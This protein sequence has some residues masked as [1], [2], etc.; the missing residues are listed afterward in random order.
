MQ[1]YLYVI[2]RK[3]E[4]KGWKTLQNSK[5]CKFSYYNIYQFGQWMM[6]CFCAY[7]WMGFRLFWISFHCSNSSLKKY[8]VETIK[9]AFQ[10]DVSTETCL[11]YSNQ[12]I[13]QE[14]ASWTNQ[15]DINKSVKSFFLE[16]FF[17]FNQ[18][19][20]QKDWQYHPS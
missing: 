6:K 1:L 3:I 9:Y 18:C 14:E 8:P 11:H 4:L 19:I 2:R 16:V 7:P 10:T 17:C 5:M 15:S 12:S 20:F 13:K